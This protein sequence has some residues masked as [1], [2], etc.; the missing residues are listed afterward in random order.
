MS[1]T[2]ATPSRTPT[3]LYIVSRSSR[4]DAITKA[5]NNGVMPLMI[6]ARPT[7]TMV[8][9]ALRKLNGTAGNRQCRTGGSGG[10][11]QPAPGAS[12][13]PATAC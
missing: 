1:T 13:G 5:V 2:P 4:K 12:P 10:S 8:W 11:F 6:D 3:T 9:P 7:L